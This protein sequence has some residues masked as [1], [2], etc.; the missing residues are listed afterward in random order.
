MGQINLGAAHVSDWSLRDPGAESERTTRDRRT[1][2]TPLGQATIGL[3]SISK[4]RSDEFMDYLEARLISRNLHVLRFAKATHTKVA[5][6]AVIGQMVERC[7][8]VV[9]GLAD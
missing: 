9:G 1:P 7:D 4:E 3:F 2:S 5:T 6:E 8:V